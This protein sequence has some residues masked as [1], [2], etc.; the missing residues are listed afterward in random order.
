M[1]WV[2]LGELNW[3]P[4]H[5]TTFRYWLGKHQLGLVRDRNVKDAGTA[6]GLGPVANFKQHAPGNAQINAVRLA[7]SPTPKTWGRRCPPKKIYNMNFLPRNQILTSTIALLHVSW[8]CTR[9]PWASVLWTHRSNPAWHR[10]EQW[11]FASHI[12]AAQVNFMEVC[13]FVGSQVVGWMGFSLLL[14]PQVLL[15]AFMPGEAWAKHYFLF[16]YKLSLQG[17]APAITCTVFYRISFFNLSEK[18]KHIDRFSTPREAPTK[19]TP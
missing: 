17:G 11:L 13:H 1:F 7:V 8:S 10:A 3:Y 19:P 9:V 18:A 5:P 15:P 12:N 6:L 2:V 16:F 4:M 14:P